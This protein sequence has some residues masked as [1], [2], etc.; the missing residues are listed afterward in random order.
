MGDSCDVWVGSAY[1]FVQ[2]TSEKVFLPVLYENPQQKL[3]I[4]K[5]LK[6][7]LAGKCPVLG[8]SWH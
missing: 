5:A 2:S 4:F 1:L 3:S 7:A 6:L 8:C